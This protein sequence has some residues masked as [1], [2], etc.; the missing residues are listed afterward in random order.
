MLYKDYFDW[1][2]TVLHDFMTKGTS[3][4]FKINMQKLRASFAHKDSFFSSE[5][6]I[7]PRNKRR[8]VAL[9]DR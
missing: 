1:R 7:D 5:D 8:R 9:V 3:V 4:F 2:P 6:L